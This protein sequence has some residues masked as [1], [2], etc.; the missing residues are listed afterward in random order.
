[1]GRVMHVIER[2]GL[3][4][5]DAILRK[6]LVRGVTQ[7]IR[8]VTGNNHIWSQAQRHSVSTTKY[9]NQY[10]TFVTPNR[11]SWTSARNRFSQPRYR[12]LFSWDFNHPM[13]TPYRAGFRERI[14][15]K[16]WYPNLLTQFSLPRVVKT[17]WQTNPY[18]VT[19][20]LTNP[21]SSS[22]SSPDSRLACECINPMI[23][24]CTVPILSSEWPC[25]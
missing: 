13:M 15:W 6:V 4:L 21:S 16:A 24:F 10:T 14:S 1:M 5:R 18:Q 25:R 20:F 12:G 7:W 3:N 9:T 19:T 2:D 22:S 23:I 17:R 11:P 8:G